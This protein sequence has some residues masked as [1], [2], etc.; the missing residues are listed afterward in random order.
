MAALLD[1]IANRNV[2]EAITTGRLRPPLGLGGR[3]EP[4]VRAVRTRPGDG[5]RH[6]AHQ[7]R[8][9]Q[10]DGA[11]EQRADQPAGNGRAGVCPEARSW[12][13][14]R[15]GRWLE[16]PVSSFQFAQIIPDMLYFGSLGP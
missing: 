7:R 4:A 6:P 11:C 10:P 12:Q 13:L 5:N 16:F 15:D 8:G 2:Y 3:V 14:E 9:L 1:R